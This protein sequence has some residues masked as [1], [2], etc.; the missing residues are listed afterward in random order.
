[1]VLQAPAIYYAAQPYYTTPSDCDRSSTQAAGYIRMTRL[2]WRHLRSSDYCNH[3][4]ANGGTGGVVTQS[5][6]STAVM[7]FANLPR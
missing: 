1:M 2:G 7:Q 3:D 6:L 4:N 5:T